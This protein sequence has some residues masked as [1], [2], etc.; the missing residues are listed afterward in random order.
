M[1]QHSHHHSGNESHENTSIL[2]KFLEEIQIMKI[3]TD[4]QFVIMAEEIKTLNK[5]DH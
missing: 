1:S 3:N 4:L 2:R 5:K